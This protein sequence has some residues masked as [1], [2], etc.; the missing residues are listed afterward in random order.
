[1][2]FWIEYYTKDGTDIIFTVST[3]RPWGLVQD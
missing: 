2:T 1:M 3:M